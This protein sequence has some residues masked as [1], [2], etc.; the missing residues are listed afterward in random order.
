MMAF[1]PT[2]QTSGSIQVRVQEAQLRAFLEE[3]RRHCDEP[4]SLE[5]VRSLAAVLVAAI[6][7]EERKRPH[8]EQLIHAL[9]APFN[10]R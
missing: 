8:L 5:S 4:L 10:H 6:E 2:A 7:I 9:R 1:L 3:G